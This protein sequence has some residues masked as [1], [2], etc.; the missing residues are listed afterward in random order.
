MNFYTYL[1]NILLI[2]IIIQLLP[3]IYSILQ[4]QYST[5]TMGPKIHVGKIDVNTTIND[6]QSYTKQLKQ[7]FEKDNVDAVMLAIDSGGGNAGSAQSIF[8]D[9]QQL[10]QKY[11][12]LF[13]ASTSPIG[14]ISY[15][16]LLGSNSESG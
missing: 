9:I 8:H 16:F 11:N 3:G 6:A 12:N 15:S 14:F 13:T 4:E 1:R 7:V 2:L 10:K 5:L